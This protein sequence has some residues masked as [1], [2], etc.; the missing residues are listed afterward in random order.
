ME[1]REPYFKEDRTPHQCAECENT[2]TDAALVD[3]WKPHAWICDDCCKTSPEGE[4]AS[5]ESDNGRLVRKHNP[6]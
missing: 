6:K 1:E 3:E 4:G 2:T 5:D